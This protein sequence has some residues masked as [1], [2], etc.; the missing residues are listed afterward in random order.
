M[1]SEAQ[2]S[3]A[4]QDHVSTCDEAQFNEKH[5]LEDE[6]PVVGPRKS[7]RHN[8]DSDSRSNAHDG[9]TREAGRKRNPN[10]FGDGHICDVSNDLAGDGHTGHAGDVVGNIDDGPT[11]DA[12]VGNAD[13]AGERES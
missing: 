13:D 10:D 8:A 2:F 12:S 4:M 11:G 7:R 9:S 5:P 3:P 6:R 1:P